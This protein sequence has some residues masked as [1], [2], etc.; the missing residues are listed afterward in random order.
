MNL[1]MM[2][3][4]RKILSSKEG[5]R[6]GQISLAVDFTYG[7]DVLYTRYMHSLEVANCSQIMS[8][9]ISKSIGIDV[10]PKHVARIVALLHD[11][12]HTAFSHAG[13]V[14]LN[15]HTLK[16]SGGS[17]FFDGNANNYTRI[18]KSKIL[19]G[20]ANEDYI[21]ASL[22]KH[23]ESL[24][25]DQEKILRIV[26]REIK[27]DSLYL[28]ENGFKLKNN[29]KQTLQCLIMD[30]ADEVCYIISDLTD[31]L[32]ILSLDELKVMM[33]EL[34]VKYRNKFMEA[35]KGKNIFKAHLQ[36]F[37]MKFA[38]N[39]TISEDGQLVAIDK[40][41]E[42]LRITLAA[43]NKKYIINNKKILDIR[44][45]NGV[46]LD[47]VFGFLFNFENR[48]ITFPSQ[49]YR[50]RFLDAKSKEEKIK[51]IRDMSG[52]F[53]DKGIVDFYNKIKNI[54]E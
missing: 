5:R 21:L 42:E 9:S 8:A 23:P 24:Y 20:Y 26:D 3:L 48:K 16:A 50:K 49:F 34:P 22:C 29:L 31:A 1:E 13:E 2:E 41:I 17:V 53:T 25:E 43:L 45:K 51:A 33:S 40:D 18:K 6:L 38:T 11:I 30:T 39:F 12:G 14:T 32:N 15:D 36:T 46:I 19:K 27:N 35:T 44:E 4:E 37:F 28:R 47:T 52:S 10:D 54:K 7:K